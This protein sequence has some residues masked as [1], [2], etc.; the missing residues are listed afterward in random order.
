[1]AEVPVEDRLRDPGF[2][3]DLVHR[4]VRA[5][6]AH[7]AVG[8]GEQLPARDRQDPISPAPTEAA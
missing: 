4:R 5:A 1:V 7:D 8:R 6:T 3:R 2:G